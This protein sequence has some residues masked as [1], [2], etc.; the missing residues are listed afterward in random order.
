MPMPTF[1]MHEPEKDSIGKM[2][3]V[4]KIGR[5]HSALR[6]VHPSVKSG[7][8]VHLESALERDFCCLLE[9]GPDILKYV[10]QPVTIVYNLEGKSRRYT[11]DF[12]IIYEGGRPS[13]LAEVKYR[14]D[15]RDNWAELKPKFR[16]AQQYAAAKGWEFRLY[17]ELEIQT[18]Y[19]QNVKLLLRFKDPF[20]PVRL[21]WRHLLLEKMSQLSTS[22]PAELVRTAFGNEERGAEI[23]PVLWHLVSRRLIGSDLSQ[24]LTMQS[25]IWSTN[26]SPTALTHEQD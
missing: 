19:L 26:P 15:L 11:P 18:A 24:S 14:V 4:R 9:F 5:S 17:T 12:L 3:P 1:R 20:L 8:L 23:L 10:E 7:Q 25:K 21:E 22:T 6:A 13:V 2:L 16:A